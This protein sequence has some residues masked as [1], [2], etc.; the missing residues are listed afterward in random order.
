VPRIHA[1]SVAENLEFRQRALLEASDEL[2]R[3][4]GVSAVT[5]SAAADACG[6]SRPAAYEY[7]ASSAELLGFALDRQGDQ[8]T[9][10]IARALGPA[11]D[12][13]SAIGT[14]VETSLSLLAPLA[15]QGLVPAQVEH[16]HHG[17]GVVLAETLARVGALDP[18]LTARVTSGV[19]LASLAGD[20]QGLGVDAH[21]L[22]QFIL[23]GLEAVSEVRSPRRS[24]A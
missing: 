3:L 23:A 9:A 18:T 7:F 13:S 1:P 20:A 8:W 6:L 21:Y 24:R 16:F 17:P 15:N 11:T 14:F 10:D 2:L 4:V 19:V 22:T 5:M 12:T